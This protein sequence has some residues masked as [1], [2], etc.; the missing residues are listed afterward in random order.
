MDIVNNKEISE[1]MTS[2][3]LMVKSMVKEGVAEV[4]N[5]QQT[6]KELELQTISST[7]LASRWHCSKQ[8]IRNRELDGTIH[9]VKSHSKVKMYLMKDILKVEALGR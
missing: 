3:L 8:T 6:Q 7:D 9:P 1:L 2:F 5:E 4:L